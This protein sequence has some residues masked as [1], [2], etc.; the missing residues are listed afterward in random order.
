MTV[1]HG[2]GPAIRPTSTALVGI[3][4]QTT[5]VDGL[6]VGGSS[7]PARARRG[8]A[9]DRGGGRVGGARAVVSVSLLRA[10]RISQAR[11]REHMPVCFGCVAIDPPPSNW[12]RGT[13]REV[14][15][16]GPGHLDRRVRPGYRHATP[17]MVCGEP[18]MRYRCTQWCCEKR[19]GHRHA[20]CIWYVEDH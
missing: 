4:S 14:P 1:I 2:A 9:D 20:T 15:E 6:C 12:T 7:A 11:P 17:C 19:P 10:C 13:C 18:L 16:V 3:P 8:A 5:V